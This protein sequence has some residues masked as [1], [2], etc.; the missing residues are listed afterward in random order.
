[1]VPGSAGIAQDWYLGVEVPELS[2]AYTVDYTRLSSEGALKKGVVGQRITDCSEQG[3]KHI[4][5]SKLLPIQI[6]KREGEH[7]Q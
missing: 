3:G 5:Q 7:S 2:A 1:M 6:Q 4:A